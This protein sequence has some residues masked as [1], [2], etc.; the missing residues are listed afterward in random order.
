MS[1]NI[2][3]P[4]TLDVR[5]VGAEGTAE[6]DQVQILS[7]NRTAHTAVMTKATCLGKPLVRPSGVFP[8]FLCLR[9]GLTFT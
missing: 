6:T 5:G 7:L 1:S 8:I 2:L 9:L 3:N 4:T